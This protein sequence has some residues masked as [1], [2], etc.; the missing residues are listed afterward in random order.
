MH[1]NLKGHEPTTSNKIMK[2]KKTQELN[3]LEKRIYAGSRW[4]D[5]ILIKPEPRTS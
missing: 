4:R 5:E 1:K 3:R 2:K